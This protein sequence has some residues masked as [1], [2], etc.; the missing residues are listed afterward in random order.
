MRNRRSRG[1]ET[2][3][4]WIVGFGREG[5]PVERAR[6]DEKSNRAKV[7]SNASTT[8][9]KAGPRSRSRTE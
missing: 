2:A 4:N 3:S 1:P 7:T 9:A 6:N 8:S 5:S